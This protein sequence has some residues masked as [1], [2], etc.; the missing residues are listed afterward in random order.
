MTL[1]H[2]VVSVEFLS[3]ARRALALC[4]ACVALAWSA[5]ASGSDECPCA[6]EPCPDPWCCERAGEPPAGTTCGCFAESQPPL[7]CEC[8]GLDVVACT[9]IEMRLSTNIITAR[10]RCEPFNTVDVSL[11][12]QEGPGWEAPGPP[13]HL[14]F[15]EEPPCGP[16]GCGCCGGAT[17]VNY[18]AWN[19]GTESRAHWALN[20]ES[21]IAPLFWGWTWSEQGG[22]GGPI[23]SLQCGAHHLIGATNLAQEIAK[24]FAGAPGSVIGQVQVAFQ[25]GQGWQ[26]NCEWGL[27][28]GPQYQ[29]IYIVAPPDSGGCGSCGSGIGD[30]GLDPVSAGASVG[31]AMEVLSGPAAQGRAVPCRS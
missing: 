16:P 8:P 31:A 15:C 17:P 5:D 27:N 2:R 10:S 26:L 22:Y 6:G 20:E 29:T 11:V 13:L 19:G 7:A 24:N 18:G 28:G 25:P 4:C 9:A 3:R 30:S 14:T 21:E 1:I 23:Q 12:C